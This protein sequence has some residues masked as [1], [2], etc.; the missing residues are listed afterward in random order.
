[1]SPLRNNPVGFTR[2]LCARRSDAGAFTLIE[3]IIVIIILAIMAGVLL[4]RIV[5]DSARRVEAESRRVQRLVNIAAERQAFAPEPIAIEYDQDA[6]ELRLAVRREPDA[7]SSRR[8]VQGDGW[9][10][11]PIVLPV[12]LSDGVLSNAWL[13]GRPLPARGW[14]II[15]SPLEPR[16]A[17]TLQIDPRTAGSARPRPGE[18]VFGWQ[19]SLLPD[20]PAATRT[21]VRAGE[22]AIPLLA[23][24]AV[25][26][27][28]AGRGDKPW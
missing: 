13:D 1:M 2:G 12:A 11:D 21:A 10:A 17:I 9:F 7:A 8:P 25:D 27:D 15:F 4:P 26:L 19:V 16:P 23:T 14:R 6:A 18:N 22:I 3:L 24:R 5:G 28:A 20:E